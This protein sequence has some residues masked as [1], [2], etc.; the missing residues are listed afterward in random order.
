MGW[1]GWNE[2]GRHVSAELLSVVLLDHQ[3]TPLRLAYSLVVTVFSLNRDGTR[4]GP[5]MEGHCYR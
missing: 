4:L 5:G 1:D 3:A 2:E